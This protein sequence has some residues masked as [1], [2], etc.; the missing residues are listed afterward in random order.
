MN[1]YE[2]KQIVSM[3]MTKV[4]N[5]LLAPKI[6]QFCNE[7]VEK[8]INELSYQA[9]FGH[10]IKMPPIKLDL[11]PE[12]QVIANQLTELFYENKKD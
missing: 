1:D 9:H 7:L 5:D 8:R 2:R 3:V 6:H 12:V 10:S 11:T 4:I